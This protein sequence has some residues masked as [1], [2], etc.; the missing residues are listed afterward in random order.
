MLG[1]LFS[2]FQSTGSPS[3]SSTGPVIDCPATVHVHEALFYV[4]VEYLFFNELHRFVKIIYYCLHTKLSNQATFR[5]VT[6][7][8]V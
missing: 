4:N 2:Q 5:T 1:T 8:I 3:I 7:I 6:F